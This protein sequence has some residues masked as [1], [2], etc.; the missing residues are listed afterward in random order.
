MK[1]VKFAQMKDGTREDYLLL[2]EAEKVFIAMTADRI[3]RELAQQADDTPAP[4]K[5]PNS[6]AACGF[7]LR[8]S[9]DE[10]HGRM[11][12]RLSDIRNLVRPVAM[13]SQRFSR[14]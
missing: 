1:S 3:L 12:R 4:S 11:R 2:Q 7:R 6:S 14:C 10:H 5:L 13:V 9:F 8:A